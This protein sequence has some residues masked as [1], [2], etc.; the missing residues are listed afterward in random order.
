MN[1]RWMAGLRLKQAAH[2]I[3]LEGCI[4]AVE[5]TTARRVVWRRRLG[6]ALIAGYPI[7]SIDSAERPIARRTRF[8]AGQSRMTSG[9]FPRA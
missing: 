4:A 8:S 7:V 2:H 9:A 3:V 1:C 5:T 6:G